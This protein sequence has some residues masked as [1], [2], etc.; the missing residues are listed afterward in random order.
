MTAITVDTSQNYLAW[1]N[2]EAV[3][4]TSHQNAP[5]GDKAFALPTAKRRAPKWKELAA[6]GGVYTGQ[7]LVWLLPQTVVSAAGAIGNR[8][9]KPAD[10]I[11]DAAGN[12]WTVL[13]AAYNAIRSTWMLT[14]RNLVLAYGLTDTLSVKRPSLTTDAAGGRT[15]TYTTVYTGILARIQE[16]DTQ[17]KDERGKRV[18]VKDY[19]IYVGTR[20]VLTIEDQ[21]IDQAD[22]VYEVLGTQDADRIDQ[23]QQV[24][25]RRA[26]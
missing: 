10:T 4:L 13:E 23:L 15:Y 17:S 6:S 2:T 9:P 16:T 7:D 8:Q 19:T 18:T 22:N 5:A 21:V 20:L 12:V 25:A 1:N 3:T 11:E 24:K 26:W 14:C